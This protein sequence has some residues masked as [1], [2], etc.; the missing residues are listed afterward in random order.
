MIRYRGICSK[1]L[2]KETFMKMLKTIILALCSFGFVSCAMANQ[3][4]PQAKEILEYW[5]GPLPSANDFQKRDKLWWEGG[6]EVDND[7]RNRF[8]KLVTAATKQELN[9]W[10]NTPRGRLALI[11]LLDQFTRNIYRGTPQ[12]FAYDKMAQQLTLEGLTKGEDNKLF[13]IEKVFFYLPLEHAENIDLQKMSVDKFH[14]LVISVPS[15]QT[16]F[17]K[18]YEDYAKGHY[19]I[20]VK[21]GRFPYRN[22][23]LNRTSTPEELEYLKE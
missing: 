4:P 15:D 9:D 10:K 22:E 21:F 20:I 2:S 5:F 18:G 1:T 16:E 12:A 17:F 23:V 8:G 6:V 3:E 19:D 13:P 7:I 14:S 11:I